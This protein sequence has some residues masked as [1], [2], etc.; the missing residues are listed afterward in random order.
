MPR[1]F[2]WCVEQGGQHGRKGRVRT[3]KP[4]DD[5]YI[6][7]CYDRFNKSHA[8]EVHH[9]GEKKRSKKRSK[10]QSKKQSQKQSKKGSEEEVYLGPRG[11]R[12]VIRNGR[13]V[14]Q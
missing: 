5:V 14:Y 12:Y 9:V 2:E 3:I 13:K 4:R 6:H 1:D 10:K 11:G 8:G 7:I